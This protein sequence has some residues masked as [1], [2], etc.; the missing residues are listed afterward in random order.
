MGDYLVVAFLWKTKSSRDEKCKIYLM[1]LNW[2]LKIVKIVKFVLCTFH[3]HY[4]K[5]VPS[6]SNAMNAT[7]VF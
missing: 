4:F 5:K 7:C 6:L 2:M 1:P 3:L